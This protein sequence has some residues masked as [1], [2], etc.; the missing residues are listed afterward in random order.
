MTEYSTSDL[1]RKSGDITLR[2][3]AGPSLSPSETSRARCCSASKTIAGS[4]PEPTPGRPAG[5][6]RCQTSCLR[7]SSVRSMPMS[8]R[9]MTREPGR[10]S[11]RMCHSLPL[12]LG[13]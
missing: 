10:A 7:T 13:T 2:R 11:H 3:C 1:S 12:S 9:V 8:G 6:R 5:S 4:R